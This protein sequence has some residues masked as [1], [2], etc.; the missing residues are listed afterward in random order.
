VI[1][2]SWGWPDLGADGRVQSDH[3]CVRYGVGHGAAFS[4]LANEVVAFRGERS[5][6]VLRGPIMFSL[7]SL[8][9]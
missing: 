2:L 7:V 3:I 5:S 9:S 1:G 4:M 6:R 8:L